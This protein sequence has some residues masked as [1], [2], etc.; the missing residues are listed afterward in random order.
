MKRSQ[1]VILGCLIIAAIGGALAIGLGGSRSAADSCVG[2]RVVA[3]RATI[4]GDRVIA[5]DAVSARR[6]DTLTI[7][8]EDSEA[9]EVA[10]GLHEDHVPYDGVSERVLGKGQSVLVTLNET[11]SFRWHDHLHDEVQGRFT[12]RD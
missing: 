8:N 3:Y 5:G 4:R 6:C 9:R 11:G 2:V 1:S 10:F 7:T 12:V